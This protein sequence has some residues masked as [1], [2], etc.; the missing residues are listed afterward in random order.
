MGT[1]ELRE[2]RWTTQQNDL[3]V[4]GEEGEDLVVDEARY[5][6]QWRAGS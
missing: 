5:G 3:V 2:A 4:E 1:E 6:K